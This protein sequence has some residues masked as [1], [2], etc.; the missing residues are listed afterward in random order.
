MKDDPDTLTDHEVQQ[1]AALVETLERSAFDFLQ[2]EVGALKL[3]IGKGAMPAAFGAQRNAALPEVPRG[4]REAAATPSGA[5]TPSSPLAAP[6]E[7]ERHDGTVP[8]LAPMMGCFYLRPEPSQPPFVTIGDEVEESTSVALIEV[9]KVFTSVLAGVRG[10]IVEICAQDGEFVE[11]Q[12]VLFR[13]R[14]VERQ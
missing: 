14:P 2:V 9:M 6:A 7:A 10:V 8:V 11:Y 5:T 13:V 3:T 12:H 1:I 4:N